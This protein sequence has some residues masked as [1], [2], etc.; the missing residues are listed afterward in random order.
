MA[1]LLEKLELKDIRLAQDM[2]FEGKAYL[3]RIITFD[4]LVLNTRA[5]KDGKKYWIN[6]RAEAFPGSDKKVE[7]R[8]KD[9]SDALSKYAFEVDEKPGK[10]LTCE[11][12]N[13]L[14]GAGINACA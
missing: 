11:H 14:E 7:T 1:K 4:G 3:G 5:I 10:K 6:L 13:L 2:P 9:I 12:I 8:A